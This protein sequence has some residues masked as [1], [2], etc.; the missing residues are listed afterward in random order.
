MWYA[1]KKMW[2]IREM[3][4][5]LVSTAGYNATITAVQFCIITIF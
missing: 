4:N 1:I 3:T 2:E 5:C